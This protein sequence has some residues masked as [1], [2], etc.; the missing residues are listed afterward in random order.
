VAKNI[1]AGTYSG[2]YQSMDDGINWIHL[3]TGP[4][5]S[6]HSFAFI[7]N[8]TGGINMFAGTFKGGIFLSTDNG[9]NWNAVNSGLTYEDASVVALATWGD[10]IFATI[11]SNGGVWR[12]SLSE[13]F[14]SVTSVENSGSVPTKFNLKQNYPN[15]FNPSTKIKYSVAHSSTVLLKIY[16]VLGKEVATLINEEKPAGSYEA[17][18]DASNL[19]SGIYFYKLEAGN[20]VETKKM[21]LL[22]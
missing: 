6:V 18:F 1:F 8:G 14:A 7:P 13:I 3:D 9:K 10:Y 21:I 5:W 15:P 19:S 20:F 4:N 22:K 17:T 16:D 2:I 11:N 12:R